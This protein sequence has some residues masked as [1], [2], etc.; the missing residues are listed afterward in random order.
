MAE[1]CGWKCTITGKPSRGSIRGDGSDQCD[2]INC[3]RLSLVNRA[4]GAAEGTAGSLADQLRQVTDKETRRSLELG[5]RA[6]SEIAH[7][8][9]QAIGN[10]PFEMPHTLDPDLLDT[11]F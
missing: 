9:R 10:R 7:A 2:C 8:L 5:I 3:T 1:N 11:T 4:I 6:N